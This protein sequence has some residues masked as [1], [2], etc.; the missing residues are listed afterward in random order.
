MNETRP[1]AAAQTRWRLWPAWP[2]DDLLRDRVYRRLWLSILISS[3]GG[4]VTMLALPLTAALMLHATPTQMGL[5][6]AI[7]TLPFVLLSLPAGVWLDRVRKLPVYI[8]GE[9][10]LAVA[11]LSVPLSWWQGWLAMP[12][13]YA[14]AFVIGAVQTVAGS[15]A[16]VAASTDS[17]ETLRRNVTSPNGTTQ[18]ALAVFESRGVKAAIVEAI[19]AARDRATE[20]GDELGN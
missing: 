16:L 5:L 4:Q 19:L 8:A 20:L 13:L 10:A 14:V 17:P 3:V 12:W 18:A 7:E 1:E 9:L 6:T 11:V 15:A 2:S